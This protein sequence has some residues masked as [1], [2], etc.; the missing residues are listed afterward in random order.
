MRIR[1]L[2]LVPLLGGVLGAA[3]ALTVPRTA[4]AEKLPVDCSGRRTSCFERRTCTQWV[5]H[6][7][8]ERTTE[9]WYWYFND[10]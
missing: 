1:S 2:A 7:C 3:L 6:V 8:T 9:F 4:V 10:R 5:D